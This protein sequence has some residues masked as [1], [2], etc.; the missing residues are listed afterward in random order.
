MRK[1]L[2]T[3]FAASRESQDAAKVV[4]AR[5][6]DDEAGDASAQ[7]NIRRTLWVTAFCVATSSGCA[8]GQDRIVKQYLDT[9]AHLEMFETV[10]GSTEIDKTWVP[11]GKDPRYNLTGEEIHRF[12]HDF[13]QCV[14]RFATAIDK[15]PTEAVRALQ[16]KDCMQEAH[17]TL[18]LEESEYLN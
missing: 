3:V 12:N 11:E 15:A 9:R 4:P 2:A 14:F 1:C 16:L 7:A 5:F 17:W 13:T 18:H 6:R 10:S 8:T